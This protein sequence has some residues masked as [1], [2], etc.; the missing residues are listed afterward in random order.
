MLHTTNR[1]RIATVAKGLGELVREV[2]FVGG[3]ITELYV[4]D[5]TLI[6]DVR[7]TDDI[8]CIIEIGSRKGYAALEERLRKQHFINDQRIICRWQYKNI[9]VDVMP[10]NAAILGFSNRWYKDGMLHA[11]KYNLDSQTTI[12]ILSLPYFIACKLEAL[13][14]RGIQDIRLSKDFEDI[15]FLLHYE[16]DLA[17]AI[18]N[19]GKVTAYIQQQFDRLLA[20]QEMEEAVFCVLPAGENDIDNI[21]MIIA[22]MKAIVSR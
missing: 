15:V 5:P 6:A 3:A 10:V 9:T 22:Q 20:M 14:N 18:R 4:A 12:N 8:D 13:F 7:Q 21:A 16:M 2:V 1:E 19:A 17:A 11:V